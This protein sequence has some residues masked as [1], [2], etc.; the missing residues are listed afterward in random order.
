MGG[1]KSGKANLKEEHKE[2]TLNNI[3]RVCMFFI[4]IVIISSIFSFKIFKLYKPSY[5]IFTSFLY[6]PQA[7]IYPHPTVQMKAYR[8]LNLLLVPSTSHCLDEGVS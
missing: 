5:F 6:I 1:G 7:S 8:R 3:Y 4:D 2:F